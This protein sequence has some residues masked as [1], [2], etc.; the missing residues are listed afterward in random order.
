MQTMVKTHSSEKRIYVLNKISK[1]KLAEFSSDFM[2]GYDFVKDKMRNEGF[3]DFFL[4]LKGKFGI[5]VRDPKDFSRELRYHGEICLKTEK[6]VRGGDGFIS[7]G[8]VFNLAEL[9]NDV[10]VSYLDIKMKINEAFAMGVDPMFLY[11]IGGIWS[12]F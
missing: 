11:D 10:D 5:D 6:L 3:G 12:G 7:S 2:F 4:G 1:D 8:E 9:V